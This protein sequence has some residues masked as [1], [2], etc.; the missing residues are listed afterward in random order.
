MSF[1]SGARPH[2]TVLGIIGVA[3]LGIIGGACL[4]IIGVACPRTNS[5]DRANASEY[6]GQLGLNE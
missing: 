5:S 2:F 1:R 4:G 6:V 3:C